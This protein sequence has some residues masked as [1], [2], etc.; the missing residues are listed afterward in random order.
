MPLTPHVMLAIL[1]DNG[2]RSMVINT[3]A[4]LRVGLGRLREF[5]K[6]LPVQVVVRNPSLSLPA[7]WPVWMNSHGLQYA[8][9]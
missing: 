6:S 2:L 8:D 7:P 4:A 1:P 5:Y 3:L 9:R